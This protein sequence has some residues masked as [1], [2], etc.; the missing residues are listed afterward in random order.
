MFFDWQNIT[1]VLQEI[2]E[3]EVA[4]GNECGCQ[5][6]IRHHNEIVVDIAAGFLDRSRRQKV[7]RDHL[8]PIFSAGKPVLSTLA[9]QAFEEG[10]I[11]FDTPLA[12]VW[13]EFNSADKAG[14]TFDHALSHRAGMY[15]LPKDTPLYDWD[16]MCRN[17]AAMTPRNQ[18]G[19]KTHYHPLTFAHLVGHAMELLTGEPLAK[20]I[21]SRITIPLNIEN[22]LVFGIDDLQEEKIVPVDDSLIGNPPAWEAKVMNDPLIRRCCIPSFNGFASARGLAKFYASLRG[23]VIKASTFDLVTSRLYRA[24]DDPVKEHEWTKFA[25]GIILNGPDNDRRLFCGHGGAAGAEAFYM[26]EEDIAFAFVKN[27]L[28]PNHPDH[29]IRDRISDALQIPRRWW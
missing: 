15:L 1:G 23:G 5:L 17:L 22:A 13:Q 29:P 9:W 11:S 20:L 2:L 19:A 6:V 7:S 24:P 12:A 14:I 8:F 21:K 26:P 28:S 4:S 3:D 18:P 10:L 16:A 27:R 25:L